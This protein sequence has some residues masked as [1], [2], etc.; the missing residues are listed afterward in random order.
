M[1]DIVEDIGLDERYLQE[2]KENIVKC[3]YFDIKKNL[4]EMVKNSEKQAYLIVD[5]VS[6]LHDLG[7]ENTQ[8]MTFV[9]YCLN[10]INNEK[11]TVVLNNHVASKFDELVSNN[12]EYVADVHV[13]VSSLK[14]GRSHDV[15]GLLTVQ[16]KSKK[17]QYQFKAFD[18][19]IK[20]FHPGESIYYLYK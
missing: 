8:I 19:G 14:T 9:N 12:M 17:S 4:E 16:R 2:D 11:I 7:I 18:R 15:T 6:H 1:N 20:T 5:D 3:L 13:E 10:L